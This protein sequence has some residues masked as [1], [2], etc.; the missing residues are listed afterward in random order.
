MRIYDI[1]MPICHDMTV[2]K[3]REEN[4]PVCEMTRDYPEGARESKICMGMHT[5]THVDA[6]KHMI[7][8]GD[9][10]DALDLRQVVT[11]CRVLD[12]T[13]FTGG[14]TQQGLADKD[15]QLGEFILLKTKNSFEDA[16]DPEFV[17]LGESGARFLADKR[18]KGVGIDALGIERAQ[19]GHQTHITLFKSGITI[20]EGLRLKNIP[21]GRYFLS[22]APLSVV[23]ADGA[24]ARAVLIDA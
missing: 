22:A 17:Y 18:I 10:I 1:S 7:E 16:F 20:I 13:Y 12:L 4:R 19:P 11:E 14:I 21:E 3:D 6:P 9:G 5:G 23:D 15:I 2:Y 24:P 8:G